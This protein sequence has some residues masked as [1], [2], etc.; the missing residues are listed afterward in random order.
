MNSLALRGRINAFLSDLSGSDPFTICRARHPE[1]LGNVR[2]REIRDRE[3]DLF[4]FEIFIHTP[5][6]DAPEE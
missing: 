6:E 5:I 1:H 3:G 2:R 4:S